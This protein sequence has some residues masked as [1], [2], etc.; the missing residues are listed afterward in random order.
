MGATATIIVAALNLASAL[1]PTVLKGV[2][3]LIASIQ[4]AESAGTKLTMHEVDSLAA[5]HGVDMKTVAALI[6][7]GA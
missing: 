5:T 6:N 3:A 1:A 4:A 7:Q 2:E